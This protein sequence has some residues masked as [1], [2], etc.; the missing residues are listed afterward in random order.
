MKNKI[1]YKFIKFPCFATGF[2]PP[3]EA[4]APHRV[5]NLATS[6]MAVQNHPLPSP[7]GRLFGHFAISLR[8]PEKSAENG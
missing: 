1:V 8:T 3:R 6:A 2:V 7:A 5:A 4:A